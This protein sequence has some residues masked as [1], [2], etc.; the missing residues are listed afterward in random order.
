MLVHES[1]HFTVNGGNEDYAY[2]LEDCL[3]LA[4]TNPD[5]AVFN[6]DS[7]EYFVESGPYLS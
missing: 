7:Y 1:S 5:Q 6:A 3:T 2:G 4:S